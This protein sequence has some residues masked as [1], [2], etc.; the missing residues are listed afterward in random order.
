MKFKLLLLSVLMV[1]S[2]N[3]AQG[4]FPL[5]VGNEWHY[6]EA[7][8]A[9]GHT[10][11][12]DHK[13]KVVANKAM[14]NGKEYYELSDNL[15]L[16]KYNFVRSDS[17][18]LFGYDEESN[19]DVC[20]FDFNIPD[21]IDPSSSNGLYMVD[22]LTDDLGLYWGK[23]Y[24]ILLFK[25]GRIDYGFIKDIGLINVSAYDILIPDI[26]YTLNGCILSGTTYGDLIYG[27]NNAFPL[28]VGNE[29]RY[30][31]QEKWPTM[32][33]VYDTIKV[34]ITG[35]KLMPNNIE[36][37]ELLDVFFDYPSTRHLFNWPS[38]YI[39]TDSSNLFFYDEQLKKDSLLFNF[40]EFDGTVSWSIN[41]KVY[42]AKQY[43]AYSLP[44]Y[45]FVDSIGLVSAMGLYYSAGEYTFKLIGYTISGISTGNI[46][47]ADPENTELNLSDYKL[48]QNYPNPFNPETNIS[49]VLPKSGYVK[50]TVYD[51]TGRE[52][53]KLYQGELTSG[54][55]NFKFDG[56]ALSSGI[57]FY[58]LESSGLT[59]TK[60]M[61]LLK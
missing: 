25:L 41:G 39:R 13:L 18:K 21:T 59:Q 26:V 36:Y 43:G 23:E 16:T 31:K 53:S 11:Y 56:T 54:R 50:L 8:T 17:N 6:E 10:T 14:P 46:N 28:A 61:L 35:K 1:P 32:P 3:F 49:V 52:I 40:S 33:Y 4:Y 27:R 47:I 15:C 38:N 51:L 30:A 12:Y 45:A 37:Y 29:W 9:W 44:Q 55:H 58:R 20:L 48:E 24:I 5:E 60:K 22:T 34:K 19:G 2:F 57:Y 7:S 42:Q